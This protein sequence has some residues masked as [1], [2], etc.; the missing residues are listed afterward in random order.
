VPSAGIAE[1]FPLEP[2]VRERFLDGL[3]DIGI[4]LRHGD[5]I[6]RYESARPSWMRAG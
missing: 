3:D 4:T 1:S 6:D 2:S 5:A